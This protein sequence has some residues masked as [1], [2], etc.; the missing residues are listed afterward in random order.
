MILYKVK[1]DFNLNVTTSSGTL[2]R[3]YSVIYK[4]N[5]RFLNILNQIP[6]TNISFD[7]ANDRFAYKNIK[8]RYS[9]TSP[10]LRIST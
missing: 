1:L 8:I 10:N 6:E 5:Q 4:N 9:Y 3:L 2:F 7:Q